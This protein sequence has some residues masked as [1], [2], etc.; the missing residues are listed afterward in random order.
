MVSGLGFV[1]YESRLKLLLPQ[2]HY[3]KHQNLEIPILSSNP[4][5][6]LM[7]NPCSAC[8]SVLLFQESCAC[9]S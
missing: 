7:W 3:L 4:L 5:S 9:G 2:N 6:L 8:T 1:C